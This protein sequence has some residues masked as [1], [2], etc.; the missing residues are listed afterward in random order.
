MVLWMAEQGMF[1]FDGTSILPVQCM[2]RSWINDDIDNLNVR[3]QACAVHVENFN[4]WWWFFPQNGQPYNTRAVIYNYKEGWWGQARMSRSAGV[5]ASYAS[6]TIMADGTL[7]AQH[8]VIS[9]GQAMTYWHADAPWA[10]TFDLNMA[11]GARLVTVKQ[12]LPDIAAQETN[13]PTA[14]ASAISLVNYSLF[15]RNSRSI[16]APELQTAQIQVRPN[17]YVDFRT[18]GRDIRLRFSILDPGNVPQIT[19]GQHQLDVVVRG[20]R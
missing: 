11:N 16:G 13:D 1:S 2:V 9:P 19:V 6:H 14:I 10:E 5:T 20:D 4:E 17:G 15:Y 18:T 7:A 12:L 3:E 8:E